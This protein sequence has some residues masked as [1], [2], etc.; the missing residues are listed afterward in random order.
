MGIWGGGGGIWGEGF[1]GGDLGEG[2]WG[3]GFGGGGGER[4]P[5]VQFWKSG[6]PKFGMSSSS[7]ELDF[8][9]RPPKST[10]AD[11]FVRVN[12]CFRGVRPA[13]WK[14]TSLPTG[15]TS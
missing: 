8:G 4:G 7:Q 2:I 13:G 10:R 12:Y 5:L 11:D 15:G 3:R 1:G 14:L 6:S 9:G